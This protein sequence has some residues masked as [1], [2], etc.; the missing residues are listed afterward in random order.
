MIHYYT[1]KVESG[2]IVKIRTRG[3]DEDVL[4]EIFRQRIYQKFLEIR[5]GDIIVDVGA[6][7]GAFS[8]A[9]AEATGA[10]GFVVAIEPGSENFCLLESNTERNHRS[11]IKLIKKGAWSRSGE[12]ALNL[13]Q[14]GGDNSFFERKGKKLGTETVKVDM[15]DSILEELKVERVNSI[16]IDTEG[17]ELEVLKGST[18][19]LARDKPQIIMETHPFGAGKDAISDFLKEFSYGTNS[20]DYWP[21]GGLGLLYAKSKLN[22]P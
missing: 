1:V 4:F 12:E 13:Y 16:K 15:L 5:H 9:A 2:D 6:N 11:N 10:G 21:R 22:Y 7:I 18:R 8:L 20:W 14:M 19:I 17:S 3:R